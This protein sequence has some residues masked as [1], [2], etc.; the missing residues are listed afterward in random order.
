V[1][2]KEE[3]KLYE[4]FIIKARSL[5]VGLAPVQAVQTDDQ[6]KKRRKRKQAQTTKQATPR[7]KDKAGRRADKKSARQTRTHN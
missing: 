6:Q 3:E 5:L 1:S 4:S 2:N 7:A